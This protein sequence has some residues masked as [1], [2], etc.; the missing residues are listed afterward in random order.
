MSLLAVW[1][2]RRYF[3]R[4]A[5]PSP[6]FETFCRSGAVLGA[7]HFEPGSA[8][9]VRADIVERLRALE[10]VGAP[11]GGWPWPN[12]ALTLR[13]DVEEELVL[14][15]VAGC[16]LLRTRETPPPSLLVGLA[17]LKARLPE[18]VADVWI[19]PG[20]HYGGARHDPQRTGWRLDTTARSGLAPA[21]ELGSWLA[22]RRPSA[23]SGAAQQP[24]SM[25]QLAGTQN[26]D[27][28]APQTPFIA[29]S[30]V[31]LQRRA[32]IPRSPIP[33]CG[34]T[35]CEHVSPS[36]QRQVGCAPIVQR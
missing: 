2:Y 32:Q 31:Q 5:A 36:S 30:T 4:V 9:G 14:L 29:Q 26:C 11:L 33:A 3:E 23:R 24:P 7:L 1:V 20:L 28:A 6:E 25:F 15:H 16:A 22:S 10:R 18:A 35:G 34:L 21:E 8:T 19:H 27:G 17:E 13:V 12:Y